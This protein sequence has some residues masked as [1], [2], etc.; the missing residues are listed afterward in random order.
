MVAQRHFS[1]PSNKDTS[2]VGVPTIR[3]D[4]RLRGSSTKANGT[5]RGDVRASRSG[6]ARETMASQAMSDSGVDNTMEFP[7]DMGTQRGGEHKWR[8]GEWLK[9]TWNLLRVRATLGAAHM[10]TLLIS[11]IALLPEWLQWVA[12][13]SDP[14]KHPEFRV[15]VLMF[16]AVLVPVALSRL[17]YMLINRRATDQPVLIRLPASLDT[18]VRERVRSSWNYELRR[19]CWSLSRAESFAALWGLVTTFTLTTAVVFLRLEESTVVPYRALA[20]AVIAAAGTRFLRDFARICVRTS[21]D[22][23]SKRMFAEALH[24]LILSVITTVGVALLGRALGLGFPLS[25]EK[26]TGTNDLL[27][28]VGLG[29]AVAILGTPAFELL[30]RRLGGVMQVEVR[31]GKEL[32]PLGAL[33]GISSSEVQRLSE[34]G[35]ESVEGLVDTPISRIFLNTRFSLPRICTWI[36]RGLLVVRIGPIAAAAMNA[37]V[38]LVGARELSV[39]WAQGKGERSQAVAAV[40]RKALHLDTDDEASL[41]IESIASDPRIELVSAFG[42]TV[43]VP[44]EIQGWPIAQVT[45]CDESA[46]RGQASSA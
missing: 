36:D 39:A 44:P 6:K 20:V 21:N 43:I 38:G 27:P 10:A 9:E 22:D 25:D 28:L 40:L 8:W 19:V 29:A 15:P 34:E 12:H 33:G 11:A 16:C 35:I 4:I 46:P 42:R 24:A 3:S 17:C 31:I 13:G 26:G 7:A 1:F 45:V 14:S 18:V 2:T 5:L 23:S 41:L 32:I 37:R 30:E